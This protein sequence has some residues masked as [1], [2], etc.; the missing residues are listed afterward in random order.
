MLNK[1][2]YLLTIIRF[3]PTAVPKKTTETLAGALNTRGWEKFAIFDW[4]RRL[5]RKR[6]AIGSWLLL[7]I[8]NIKSWVA[9]RSVSIP[10]TL[11]DLE[12][13]DA[14]GL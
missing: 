12:R 2:T 11:S 9:D 5:S 8:T 10:M 14:M 7:W 13:R 3:S 1:I 6:Y 4:S